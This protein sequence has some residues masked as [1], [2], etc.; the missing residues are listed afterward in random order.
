MTLCAYCHEP[1]WFAFFRARWWRVRGRVSGRE[2]TL[3][4]HP[5][6][7]REVKAGGVVA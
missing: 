1:I 4:F 3:P 7:V 6:C 5:A 2:R